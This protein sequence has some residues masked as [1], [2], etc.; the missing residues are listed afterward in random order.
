MF[1]SR[2]HWFA[3]AYRE[4]KLTLTLLLSN[5]LLHLLLQLDANVRL[6]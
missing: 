4:S 2:L 5:G 6:V 1:R 3:F